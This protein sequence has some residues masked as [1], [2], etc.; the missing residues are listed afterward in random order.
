MHSIELQIPISQ[1]DTGSHV[2]G[3]WSAADRLRAS[4]GDQ[5]GKRHKKTTKKSRKNDDNKGNWVQV[6]RLGNPLIN[7]VIIRTDNKDLWNRLSPAADKRFVDYYKTPILAA[8]I[9]KLYPGLNVPETNRERPGSGAPHRHPRGQQSP[10][11]RSRTSCG[12]TCRR[13]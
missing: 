5:N 8:V 7:E 13:R 6:S 4:V 10:G 2:I 12:S 1:V 3:V 9:N 11:R